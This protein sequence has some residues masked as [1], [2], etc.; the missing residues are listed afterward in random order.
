M[1]GTF[2][3]SPNFPEEKNSKHEYSSLKHNA[4]KKV[5]VYATFS[6][7]KEWQDKIFSGIIENSNLNE[8]IISDPTNGN[9]Y[10]IPIQN[11]NYIEFEE[12]INH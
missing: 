8:L 2:F 11:I 3:N 4:S 1:N 6:D 12:K 7:S 9:W 10:L 5:K